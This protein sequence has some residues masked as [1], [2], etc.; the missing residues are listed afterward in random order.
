VYQVYWPDPSVVLEETLSAVN[1]FVR[2]GKI[3]Y[4]RLSNFLGCI[5]R[6]SS[7]VALNWVLHRQG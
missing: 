7:Q 2:A 1:D 6:T 5:C 4:G 3:R